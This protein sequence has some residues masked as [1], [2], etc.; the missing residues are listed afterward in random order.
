MDLVGP[1]PN[2]AQGH[3]YI[4]AIVDYSM[5]PDTPWQSHFRKASLEYCQGTSFMSCL[6]VDLSR[7]LQVK[8]L[9]MSVYHLQIDGLV[10]QFNQTLKWILRK[11]VDKERRTWDLPL[12]YIP[13]AV[14]EAPQASVSF[15]LFELQ[16]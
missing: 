9:K 11:V 13:F 4:L 14:C 16:S 10:E 5:P 15:S 12:P 1:L 8:H 6:M 7:V 2:S 3:E